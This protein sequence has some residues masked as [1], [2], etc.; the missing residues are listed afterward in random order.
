MKLITFLFLFSLAI[1]PKIGSIDLVIIFGILF[2]IIHLL[3]KQKT[4]FDKNFLI[5][6][7]LILLLIINS[8]ISLSVNETFFGLLRLIKNILLL[9][10]IPIILLNIN[11][12]FFFK[13][14]PILLLISISILYIEYFNILNLR[15]TINDIHEYIYGGRTVNYRAKGFYAGYSSAGVSCGLISIFSLFFTIKNNIKKPLGYTLFFFSFI[16]TFFTGR[17]GIFIS[18]IGIMCIVLFHLRYFFTIKNLLLF[19]CVIIS[20]VFIFSLLLN[21]IN[22]DNLY[23]TYIRTFELFINYYKEGELHSESTTQ[24]VKTFDVPNKLFDLIFGNGYEPWSQQSITANSNQSDSGI[25]QNLYIY[26]LI[27]LF[28][29]YTP[30]V[31]I[32][33]K[34]LKIKGTNLYISIMF[35]LGFISEIKG[36]YIYSSLIFT[37]ITLPYFILRK[38]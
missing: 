11:D 4:Y 25:F 33:T 14:F 15:S 28:I 34:S 6:S 2:L 31:Y 37:L 18:F 36:H 5:F 24:L 23:I 35:L 9:I 10:I 21:Y 3:S 12:K 32:W 20:L 30:I 8:F 7:S 27:G 22:L 26:G 38:K 13:I 17:T 29:Y 1:L 19:V 16:A